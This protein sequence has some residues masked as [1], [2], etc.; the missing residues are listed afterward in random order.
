MGAKAHLD[1]RRRRYR[2]GLVRL[3]SGGA[4]VAALLYQQ[5]YRRWPLERK[6]VRREDV[7]RFPRRW[8]IACADKNASRCGKRSCDRIVIDDWLGDEEVDALL[9]IA[10]RG[11][12]AARAPAA[13]GGPTIFDAN[14]GYVMAP[15]ARLA[16]IYAVDSTSPTSTLSIDDFELYR[17]AIRRLKSEVESAFPRERPLYFTA[18]TFI[19]RLSGENQSWVPS[20][21]HDE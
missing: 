1:Q 14:S 3:A 12:A 16:N 4:I 10:S 8:R 11:T 15:G 5:G 9:S 17:R 18:P 21:P 2:R 20:S 19:A 7:S 13:E 6:L